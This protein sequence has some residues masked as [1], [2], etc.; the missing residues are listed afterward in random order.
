M[1][2]WIFVFFYNRYK[3]IKEADEYDD[4]S[5]SASDYSIAMEGMPLDI[6][7]KELQT[8]FDEYFERINRSAALP[9]S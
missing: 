2:V 6:T 9:K 7:E 8:S 3:E 5:K 4:S 1:I